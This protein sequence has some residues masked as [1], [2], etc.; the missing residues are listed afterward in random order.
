M[1]KISTHQILT[2]V[3][4]CLGESA[5]SVEPDGLLYNLE[6]VEQICHPNSQLFCQFDQC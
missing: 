5:L 4:K 1:F 2:S 3:I 6:N